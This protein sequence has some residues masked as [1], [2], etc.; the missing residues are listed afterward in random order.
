LKVLRVGRSPDKPHI[1]ATQTLGYCLDEPYFLSIRAA[2]FGVIYLG[3]S[4]DPELA[5]WRG[6]HY[7][8]YAVSAKNAS[9]VRNLAVDP[10][11][12]MGRWAAKSGAIASKSVTPSA[13]KSVQQWHQRF[14]MSTWACGLGQIHVGQGLDGDSEKLLAEVG[15]E[16]GNAESPSAFALLTP[17]KHGFE[18]ISISEKG[19]KL[20]SEPEG[21]SV[22][23]GGRPEITNPIPLTIIQ[24]KLP[25]GIHVTTANPV[26]LQL[27][28]TVNEDGS[29]GSVN[30]P[31]WP[32]NQP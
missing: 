13:K 26:K 9:V 21:D 24:P 31:D 25:V 18:I 30:I 11:N 17:G 1:L 19:S 14:R 29:V 2:G 4:I 22:Y 20:A 5:G 10:Y 23:S 3:N 15:C 32:Q 6:V 28:I 12:F 7:I 16:K 8:E 27:L